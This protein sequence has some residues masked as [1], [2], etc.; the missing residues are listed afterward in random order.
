MRLT[1]T[2]AY[3]LLA[4]CTAVA[5]MNTSSS[6]EQ[7]LKHH[8]ADALSE[9]VDRVQFLYLPESALTTVAVTPE[10]LQQLSW[11]KIDIRKFHESGIYSKLTSVLNS[12]S[13]K[14]AK[15]AS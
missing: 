2:S 7:S 3:F 11:S 5:Q 9:R 6:L 14:T 15:A 12:P 1:Y 13:L 4:V 10:R 8:I